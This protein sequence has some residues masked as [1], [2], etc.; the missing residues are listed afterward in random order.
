MDDQSIYSGLLQ[1]AL[2]DELRLLNAHLPRERISLG[3]AL[4][5]EH[6]HIACSDGSMHMFK[7]KE[8]RY[9]ADILSTEEQQALLL[10]ILIK[11]NSG[12]SEITVLCRGD[13]EKKVLTQILDMPLTVTGNGITIYKNQLALLRKKLRT[14]T[15]Y[16]FSA[17]LSDIAA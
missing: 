4:H 13:T 12:Y 3:D 11:V 14:T 17:D 5:D 1:E 7:K 8:L 6:P 15:Q 10:P 9:L 16:I 2:K